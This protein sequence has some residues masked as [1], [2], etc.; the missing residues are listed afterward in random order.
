MTSVC[1]DLRSKIALKLKVS[2]I[3]FLVSHHIDGFHQGLCC[4]CPS[5]SPG[6][7]LVE[8]AVLGRAARLTSWFPCKECGPAQ[9]RAARV[10][11]AVWATGEFTLEL[12]TNLREVRSFTITEKAPTSKDNRIGHEILTLTFSFN[13]I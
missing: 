11:P 4:K 2:L 7:W 3:S 13:Y 9:P 12:E 6:W 5:K 10:V 8:R 1:E